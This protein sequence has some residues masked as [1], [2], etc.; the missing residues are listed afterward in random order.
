MAT[1]KI[2]I[3][4]LK[5]NLTLQHVGGTV[6]LL[7]RV[8]EPLRLFIMCCKVEH[9]DKFY[10]KFILRKFFCFGIYLLKL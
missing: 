5:E 8:L 6:M 1:R 9:N 7:A 4:L 2:L 3:T 10:V